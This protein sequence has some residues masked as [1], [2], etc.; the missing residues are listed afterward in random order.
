MK[1][2]PGGQRIYLRTRARRGSAVDAIVI[3]LAEPGATELTSDREDLEALA[4]HAR[5]VKVERV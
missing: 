5:G 1:Q 4:T 2:W 3:A